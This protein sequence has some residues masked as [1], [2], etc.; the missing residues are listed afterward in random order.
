MSYLAVKHLHVTCVVISGLGFGLRAW[1]MLQQSSYLQARLTRI[2]PH[3]V[4]STLL[5]S[6]IALAVMSEQYPFRDG[7]LTAKVC[8]LLAYIACGTVALKR[9]KTPG[10]RR[11]FAVLAVLAYG[12]IVGV[13]LS[14]S[15]LSVF[16]WI[17]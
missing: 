6:A 12:Y 3:I 2:L 9:G 11:G 15:P 7:W 1:W 4:D 14:R 8:G 17:V 10:L 5:V 13:A 16:S